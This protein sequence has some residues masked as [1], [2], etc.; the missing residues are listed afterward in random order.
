MNES[1][2]KYLSGL[3]DAD[4]SL[5]FESHRGYDDRVRISLKL[6]LTAS[7]EIDRQGF[8]A[9]LPELTGFGH[10]NQYNGR[11][12][13]W[14]VGHRS[15]LEMLLPR[16]IKHM[17]IKPM[18]WQWLLDFWREYR[19]QAKGQ[20]SLSQ[21]EWDVLQ[22]LSRESRKI[23]VGPVKPKNHPT[24]AWTAGYLDGDG[25]FVLRSGRNNNTRLRATAHVSDVVV[26]EFLQKA[27]GG[28]I[29]Q[30]HTRETCR[31]W[32]R[33]LGPSHRSFA[34][35][36]L[37]K[38]AKHARFKRHKIEQMIHFHRQQRLSVSAPAGEA[39]V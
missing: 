36:F 38:L 24:W 8:V 2:V 5:S 12:T 26:L 27:F 39:T 6:H 11:Y 14:F 15:H 17:V 25:T 22:A 3:L 19:S 9:S 29:V 7:N 31:V 13:Q 35:N 23:R 33:G 28:T 34:L 30:C 32:N 1:L 18:H 20:K 16:L 4:G 37:P 21:A 10:T